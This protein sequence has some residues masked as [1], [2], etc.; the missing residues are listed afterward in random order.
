M[1]TAANCEYP[2][3]EWTISEAVHSLAPSRLGCKSGN[4]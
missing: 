1:L 2:L 4:F 3:R